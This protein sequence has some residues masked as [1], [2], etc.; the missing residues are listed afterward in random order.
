MT[1]SLKDCTYKGDGAFKIKDYKTSA[2]MDKAERKKYEKLTAR[3]TAKIAELQD[4]LY[5]EAREGVVILIQAMDAAG[6]DSTIK[7]VMSGVNP[8]GCVVHSFKQPSHEELA[9]SFLWRAMAHMPQRGYLG[10]FNR[11]YYEDVLVVRVHD[12]QKG[13]AMPKRCIDMDSGKFFEKRYRQISDFEEYLWDNGYRV[14]K[15]FLHEGKDEQA[16]RF[17]ARIDD[18]AKNWKFSESDMKER[19]LWDEY[20]KAYEKAIDGTASKHAP[21]YVIPADQKW[22]ARYLVSE[23]ILAVLKDIDPHYP[24]MP[25]EQKANLAAC[26]TELESQLR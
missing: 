15:I 10:V 12:M 26:R 3:N 9:H 14:V 16:K 19:A 1:I 2:K 4:R 5:A 23:A 24:E 17:M 20:Q 13:Y 11:S 22:F 7:H 25:A 21:W 6:K 18:E 8:Q